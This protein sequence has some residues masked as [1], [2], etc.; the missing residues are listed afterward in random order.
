MTSSEQKRIVKELMSVHR[1]SE[2]DAASLMLTV[3]PIID[4]MVAKAALPSL[5]PQG[6]TG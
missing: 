3:Q 1:L 5:S 6:E 2:R 4:E